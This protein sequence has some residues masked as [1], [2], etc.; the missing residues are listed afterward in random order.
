MVSITGLPE[1]FAILSTKGTILSS[2][3]NN[4]LKDRLA[5]LGNIS[6]GGAIK[7]SLHFTNKASLLSENGAKM[8]LVPMDN[9][10]EFAAIP[11]T[12]FSNTDVPFYTNGQALLQKAVE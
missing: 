6:I 9:M 12:V 11:Q 7:R 5:L 4:N 1:K 3:Y 10:S 2:I 8:I